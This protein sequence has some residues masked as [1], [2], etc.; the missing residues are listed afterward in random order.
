MSKSSPAEGGE[1]A[2][3][4]FLTAYLMLY[5]CHNTSLYGFGR[6]NQKDN[7]ASMREFWFQY[8]EPVSR[9][10]RRVMDETHSFDSERLL[11]QVWLAPN[12]LSAEL[13][14]AHFC[15]T[16][17]SH[18]P[19]LCCLN[20]WMKVVALQPVVMEFVEVLTVFFFF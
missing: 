13:A 20:T 9:A 8:F 16:R 12:A 18:V 4:G 14:S 5:L 6:F 1:K 2:S 11:M 17:T 15:T 19:P 3:A 10:P 7:L